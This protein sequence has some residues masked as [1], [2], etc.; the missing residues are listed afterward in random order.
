[1]FDRLDIHRTV[2]LT[3]TLHIHFAASMHFMNRMSQKPPRH[4]AFVYGMLPV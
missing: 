2:D 3:M 4:R 1:L